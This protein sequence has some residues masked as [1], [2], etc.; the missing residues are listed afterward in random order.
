[1]SRSRINVQ[2]QHSA[3]VA[4]RLEALARVYYDAGELGIGV[5][6]IGEFYFTQWWREMDHCYDLE[7]LTM[8]ERAISN[9]GLRC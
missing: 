9:G 3:H 7:T 6:H 4:E 5:N 1:M 8:V 2:A